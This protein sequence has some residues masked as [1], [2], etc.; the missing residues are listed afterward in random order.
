MDHS[1]VVLLILSNED[2]KEH[3]EAARQFPAG[4]VSFKDL[5]AW[6]AAKGVFAEKSFDTAMVCISNSSLLTQNELN[7]IVKV[8]KA[9]GVLKVTYKGELDDSMLKRIKFAGLTDFEKT[10]AT[11]F[12]VTRKAWK[13]DQIGGSTANGTSHGATQGGAS[14]NPFAAALAE[15]GQS[16][17]DVE[18]LLKKDELKESEKGGSCAVKAKACK[19][20]TCGRKE[21]EEK[22]TE[23]EREKKKAAL[24]T[25]NIKSSCGNCYLGD[26][27]RCASCPYRGQPAFEPG[28]K[29]KLDFSKEQ[30]AGP[31][32]PGL[33]SLPAGVTTTSQPQGQAASVKEGKVRVE[34]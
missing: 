34:L 16:K 20:C 8:L 21:Q 5:H 2:F 11:E 31:A 32:G 12:K 25:G 19:N 22:M 10:G 6:N 24:E 23:A 28:D 1:P 3:L 7:A 4:M 14:K 27:F 17:M 29:V 15:G 33:A 30:I 18:E 13:V 9:G 26:A